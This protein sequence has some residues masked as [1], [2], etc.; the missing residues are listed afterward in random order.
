MPKARVLLVED[1]IVVRQGIKALL[2]DESDLEIVGEADNGREALPLIEKLQ[3]NVVL[4]DISMP[5]MNGIE[6]TRQVRQR[7]PE[8][9]VVI[10]SMHANEE[11]VF[12]VLRAGASGY[13]LKQSDSSEVLTAIHAALSGG[14]FLSPPISRAVIDD[15]VHRAEVRG[16]GDNLDLLTSREREVLQLLA[17]GLSNKEIAEQLSISI[18]TVETHR[19]N[20]MSKLE[21]SNKTDLIKYALRKGWATLE[22]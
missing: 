14:S 12:Q 18:K 3:P 1:H 6:A 5:G 22:E 15:Y 16:Q 8:V 21:V 2:S 9:K 13:V 10:L 11:Y 17:E 19:S 20:M 7:F 4:M